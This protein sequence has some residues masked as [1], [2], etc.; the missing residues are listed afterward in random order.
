[1]ISRPDPDDVVVRLKSGNPSTVYLLGTPSAPDQYTVRTRDEAVSQA[2]AF[3][4]R[5][6]VRAWFTSGN[7]DLCC[8]ER[9]ERARSLETERMTKAGK[10]KTEPRVIRT[11]NHSPEVASHG[12]AD[13]TDHEI[14]RR[15]YDLYLARGREDG[16][17]LEDWF[18]AEQ[19]VRRASAR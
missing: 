19:E 2:V 13:V 4:K 16:H 5:Q 1:V 12:P 14:A 11:A 17:D 8:S 15:A 18:H 9:F 3:A 10:R 6:Q 7:D